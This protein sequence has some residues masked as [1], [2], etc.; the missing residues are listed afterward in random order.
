MTWLNEDGDGVKIKV[1]VQPGG[2]RSEVLGLYGDRL[3]VRI[4]APPV[5]G[6]ANDEMI[7]FLS[8]ILALPRSHV[9]ILSGHHTRQKTIVIKGLSLVE[10]QSRL[11]AY[12]SN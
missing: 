8:E 1:H 12:A 4:H 2:M 5:D 3:K 9:Q 7:R 10:V 11:D 6:K